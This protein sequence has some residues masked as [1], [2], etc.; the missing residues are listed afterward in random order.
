MSIQELGPDLARPK[1]SGGIDAVRV[2]GVVAVVVAHVWANDTTRLLFFPWHVPVFFFLTG[3]LWKWDRAFRQEWS[4]RVKALGYPYLTWSVLV[5]VLFTALASHPFSVQSI[6]D[7]MYRD[8]YAL[9]PFQTFWFVSA[10]FFVVLLYRIVCWLPLWGQWCVGLAALT[11]GVYAGPWLANSPLSVGA[12]VSCLVFVIAGASARRVPTPAPALVGALLL[13]VSALLVALRVSA[14]VDLRAGNLGTPYLSPVVAVAISFG[15]V[16]VAEALF[17][18]LPSRV[19]TVTTGLAVPALIVV[20]LHPAVLWIVEP[21]KVGRPVEFGLALILPWVAG[22]VAVRTP[23]SVW[24]TGA[25][26]RSGRPSRHPLQRQVFEM[27]RP[28]LSR[29]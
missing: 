25:G 15:L 1:R 16:L 23:A 2:L 21:G 22:L 7:L 27:R 18:R 14:P 19:S 11:I 10:L 13:A 3:Y 5:M 9:P 24:L 12:S 4:A 26:S 28:R 29:R 6:A 17:N 8:Y 20:L